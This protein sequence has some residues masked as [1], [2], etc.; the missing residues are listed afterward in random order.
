VRGL[1]RGH[2][3]AVRVLWQ[4]RVT[5]GRELDALVAEKVMAWTFPEP[6]RDV[7]IGDEDDKWPTGE[8]R[9][10]YKCGDGRPIIS[11]FMVP[12]YSTDIRAAWKVVDRLWPE[13]SWRIV[14]DEPPNVLVSFWQGDSDYEAIAATAPLAISLAAL[15]AVGA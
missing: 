1:W 6:G 14:D 13:F 11:R 9:W 3:W 8:R 5:A 12:H 15:K 4:G 7:V 2:G 10:Y